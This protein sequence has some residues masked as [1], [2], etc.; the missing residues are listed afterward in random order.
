MIVTA[1][2]N[3][4]IKAYLITTPTAA[5]QMK[6][7]PTWPPRR[8]H[9]N[10]GGRTGQLTNS[11]S[12]LLRIWGCLKQQ[13][14]IVSTETQMWVRV[15]ITSCFDRWRRQWLFSAS[16]LS[17]LSTLHMPSLQ[18]TSCTLMMAYPCCSH[19]SPLRPASP[20]LC[21]PL[22][23]SFPP[24]SSPIISLLALVLCV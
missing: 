8:S 18:L 6:P 14:V 17:L 5:P 21:L 10:Q 15:A 11:V 12:C 20:F 7:T 2:S 22:G 19:S 1:H 4:Q 23:S 9:L 13:K 16:S 3:L 24:F